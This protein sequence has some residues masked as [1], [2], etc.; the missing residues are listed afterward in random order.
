MGERAGR[1]RF[2]TVRRLRSGRFQASYVAADGQRHNAPETFA[3]KGD[4]GRWLTMVEA[5][6]IRGTWADPERGKVSLQD[7]GQRWI[8]QR[9][10]LRPRT[11]DLYRWL[12]GRYV[13]PQLGRIRLIDLDPQQV[14]QW[15]HELLAAGVSESMA[16][17]AYRLLRAVLNTAVEDGLITKN[18]CQIRGGGT[19][20]PAERPTI[21]VSQVLDLADRMPER[22][23]PLVLLA[24]FGSLRWGEVTGLRRGDIDVERGTVTV[25]GALSERSTGEIVLGPPKTVP[26]LR[27]VTLPA[28]VLEQLRGHLDTYVE[29]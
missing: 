18:P 9:P 11:L 12:F 27:S 4:A 19:E 25:R 2:G 10:G 17:K 16:A 1:R 28:P 5:S 29:R 15:R 20:S 3:T 13:R 6:M 23:R 26:G 24:V 22:Y 7:Y 14:R 21:S 8:E